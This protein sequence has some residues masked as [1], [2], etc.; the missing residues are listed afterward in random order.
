[1]EHVIYLLWKQIIYNFSKK[2]LIIISITV[3][4]L[5]IHKHLSK[6]AQGITTICNFQDLVD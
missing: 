6:D 2:T 5:E 1:M 4:E 3:S